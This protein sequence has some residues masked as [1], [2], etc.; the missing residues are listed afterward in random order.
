MNDL[1]YYQ[2]LKENNALLKQNA[3]LKSY[4]IALLSNCIVSQLKEILEYSLGKENI[5][6]QVDVG[7]YDN[8]L[9][10]ADTF[11]NHDSVIIF[12]EIFNMVDGFFYN[13]YKFSETQ[14]QNFIKLIESHISLL[15]NVLKDTPLVFF[16]KFQSVYFNAKRLDY[17]V[18]ELNSFL[19]KSLPTNFILIDMNRPFFEVSIKKSVDWKNFYNNKMPYT[20]DFLKAYVKDIKPLVMSVQGKSK[21]VLILDCDNTLW[22]GIVGED[23]LSGIKVSPNDKVGCVFAEVQ[24]L[25]LE[26]KKQGVLLCI[27]SKNNLTDVDDILENHPDMILRNADFAIKKVNWEDKAT[28]IRAIAKELNLGIDS[29]VFIDDSDFEINLIKEKLPEVEAIQVP[30]DIYSYPEVIRNTMSLFYSKSLSD[31]DKKRDQIYRE[32]A[33]RNEAKSQF[34]NITDYLSALEIT[35]EIFFN[36]D[37]QIARMAQMTQKTNQFNLTTKRYTEKEIELFCESTKYDLLSFAVKDKYGDNGI[38]GLLVIKYSLDRVANIDS[39]LM[40]CRIIGRNIEFV[41][42]DYLVDYLKKKNVQELYSSYIRTKKNEQVSNLYDRCGFNIIEKVSNEIKY[43]L[44]LSKY[45]YS[46]IDYIC[47]K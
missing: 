34:S 17:V 13:Y 14:L 37:K 42:L 23:G 21:K 5:N 33:E 2:I 31:E 15:I 16:N 3:H 35:L 41:M 7:N 9:Q 26:L 11:K 43:K 22:K 4:R 25:A 18:D 39:F 8:I 24:S 29:F 47:I 1:K 20:L 6:A 32:Q 12:Y 40:S 10:D 36:E 44:E 30:K 28:N 46:K 27:C 38:T 45:I 19:F